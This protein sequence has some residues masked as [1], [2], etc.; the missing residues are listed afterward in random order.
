M[1]QLCDL[2]L[3][4]Q[5]RFF[6]VD[7]ET[8]KPKA[9]SFIL[10][11]VK[12]IYPELIPNLCMIGIEDNR[13]NRRQKVG[14]EKK[15]NKH[16]QSCTKPGNYRHCSKTENKKNLYLKIYPELI[17]DQYTLLGKK[18]PPAFPKTPLL[19]SK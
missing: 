12:H 15:I 2:I 10:N 16:H 3:R 17:F 19:G 8:S 18:A 9:S 6:K 13:G 14:L 4:L 7:I 5:K 11:L 1:F